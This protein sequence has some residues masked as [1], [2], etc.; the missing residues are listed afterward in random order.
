MLT[1]KVGCDWVLDSLAQEDSCGVCNGDDSTC[2]LY[3][4]QIQVLNMKKAGM[5][6][7]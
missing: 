7:R 3:N 6:I 5:V 1:Q 4:G 2:D